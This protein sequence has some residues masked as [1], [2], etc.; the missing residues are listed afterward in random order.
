VEGDQ[1]A[2]GLQTIAASL[3]RMYFAD[4]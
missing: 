4:S 2:L 3:T 1:K